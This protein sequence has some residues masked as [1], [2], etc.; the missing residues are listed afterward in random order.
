MLDVLEETGQLDNTI[1]AFTTDHGEMAGDHSM[2]EKRAFYE[3]SARI[4][5]LLR[6]PWMNKS[7]TKIG[8]VF[9]HVDLVPTLLELAGH[10]AAEE[11]Q[12]ESR[13]GVLKGEDDLFENAVFMEWNGMVLVT[14]VSETRS[15]T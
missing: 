9:G 14:V 2:L 5:M 11:L 6:V 3:E 12:G 10:E 1:I 7:Q 8:G 4:P 13:V 15:L